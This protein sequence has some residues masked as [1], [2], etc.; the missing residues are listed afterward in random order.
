MKQLVLFLLFSAFAVA[1]IS[2]QSSDSARVKRPARTVVSD[3]HRDSVNM[4]KLNN[5]G[6]LMIASGVGLCAVGGYLIYQGNKVY[7]TKPMLEIHPT[8][9]QQAVYDGEVSKNHK[10]GTI[11]YAVGG[12]AIA[13]G[14]VLTAIGARNKVEFK[15]RK[16]LMELESGLLQNGQL[17]AM[18][19]F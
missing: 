10:Q 18:L 19:T 11:Y 6:N 15:R 7:T 8:P 9:E 1:N 4:A 2:A 14:L 5:S 17:G 12:I 13:G 3:A 16:H